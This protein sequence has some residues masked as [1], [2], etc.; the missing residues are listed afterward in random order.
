MNNS[1]IIDTP[2]GIRAYNLIAIKFALKLETMGMRHSQG[3]V[4]NKV[5]EMIG[6]KTRDKK[7]LLSEYVNW[8][9]TELN[10]N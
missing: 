5:R 7:A 1:T 2:E 6:S 3:S 9:G 10:Y 4:A 8:L